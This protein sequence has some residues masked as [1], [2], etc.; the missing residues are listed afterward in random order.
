MTMRIRLGARGK[1]QYL[2]TVLW[3]LIPKDYLTLKPKLG[4]W[5][6]QIQWQ[7]LDLRV[8]WAMWRSSAGISAVTEVTIMECRGKATVWAVWLVQT[9]GAGRIDHGDPSGKQTECLLTSCL[10]FLWKTSRICEQ[11]CN[12]SLKNKRS[13]ILAIPRQEQVYG[14]EL[15]HEGEPTGE[16]LP[17]YP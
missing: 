16:I 5:K 10:I 13:Q 7:S 8:A 1:G 9:C 11:K 4:N 15:L 2:S 17:Q 6:T 14:Y 12:P 3:L